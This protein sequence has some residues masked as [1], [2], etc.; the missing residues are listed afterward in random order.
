MIRCSKCGWP[1]SS[2]DRVCVSC[3]RADNERLDV[4]Q[5]MVEAFEED[6]EPGYVN[7]S[8]RL[9]KHIM[10]DCTAGVVY[11]QSYPSRVGPVYPRAMGEGTASVRYILPEDRVMPDRMSRWQW[12]L[13]LVFGPLV[14]LPPVLAI[15]GIPPDTV[16][17]WFDEGMTRLAHVFELVES[18]WHWLT[19][20]R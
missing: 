10:S 5:L 17:A 18:G 20:E 9:D 7:R 8:Y 14:V 3:R 1:T 16:I 19:N 6:I 2:P 13:L 4:E 15:L 11:S 12:L